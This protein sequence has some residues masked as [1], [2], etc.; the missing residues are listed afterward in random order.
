VK[1]GVRGG[2]EGTG[3]GGERGDGSGE[4]DDGHPQPY[5]EAEKRT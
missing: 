5:N 3:H 2:D 1:R 4:G